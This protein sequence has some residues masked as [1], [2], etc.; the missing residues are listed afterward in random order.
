MNIHNQTIPL[1]DYV[2]IEGL[3]DCPGNFTEVEL[4]YTKNENGSRFTIKLG[5]QDSKSLAI[6]R[7]L[8]ITFLK[9]GLYVETYT[10]PDFEAK[11]VAEIPADKAYRR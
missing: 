1:D 2:K 10:E 9:G 5:A 7:T 4:Q 3:K 11:K 6:H 8:T